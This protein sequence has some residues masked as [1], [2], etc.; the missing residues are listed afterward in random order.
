ML[1]EILQE[2]KGLKQRI[3]DVESNL[4]DEIQKNRK[5]LEV[6]REEVAKSREDIENNAKNIKQVKYK[7]DFNHD[8]LQLV[9]RDL[10]RLVAAE[11]ETDLELNKKIL[12]EY[13]VEAD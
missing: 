10:N 6:I 4:T 9:V 1:Q 8:I 11:T 7:V 2:V 5:D 3:N 12:D 13:E